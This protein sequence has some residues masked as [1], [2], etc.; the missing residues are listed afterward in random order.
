L[1]G[2]QSL[3]STKCVNLATG[4]SVQ[5]VRN[6]LNWATEAQPVPRYEKQMLDDSASQ[7][8]M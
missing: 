3:E 6:G 8:V 2:V 4:K 5:A 1:A 7:C